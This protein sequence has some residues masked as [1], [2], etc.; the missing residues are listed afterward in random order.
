MSQ[1]KKTMSIGTVLSIVVLGVAFVYLYFFGF[2]GEWFFGSLTLPPS[3]SA[4]A[5]H[6]ITQRV[7][8]LFVLSAVF[9][10][11]YQNAVIQMMQRAYDRLQ[12]LLQDEEV[13][14]DYTQRG[15]GLLVLSLEL[16]VAVRGIVHWGIGGTWRPALYFLLLLIVSTFLVRNIQATIRTHTMANPNADIKS[17]AK[18]T[19][20]DVRRFSLV[21]LVLTAPFT[22][23]FWMQ[24]YLT[25]IQQD[26]TLIPVPEFV[27]PLVGWEIG[28]FAI[29]IQTVVSKVLTALCILGT[30]F[31]IR[32]LAAESVARKRIKRE[33][34]EKKKRA[35]EEAKKA[36]AQANASQKGENPQDQPR[37]GKP[38]NGKTGGGRNR[39]RRDRQ[40]SQHADQNPASQDSGEE[41]SMTD[42]A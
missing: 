12:V 29:T 9:W 40:K 35:E 21:M 8:L 27:V 20:G 39:R 22:Y 34:E 18:A 15:L 42:A 1:N 23:L 31:V 28:A 11:V 41:L 10:I 32:T 30:P 19:R 24:I 4:V 16:F 26:F 13:V 6:G 14:E 7:A 33:E 36:S 37:S 38:G 2:I 25:N 3:V 17:I 5:D